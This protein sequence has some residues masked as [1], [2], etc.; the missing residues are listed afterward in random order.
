MIYDAVIL[1]ID[2]ESNTCIVKY[3][4]YG[5]KEEQ[6]LADLL[7]PSRVDLLEYSTRIED[8]EVDNQPY[9]LKVK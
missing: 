5:N 2:E 3:D 1:T 8:Q 4:G 9:K 6:Y 7:P